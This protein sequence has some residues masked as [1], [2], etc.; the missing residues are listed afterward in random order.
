MTTQHNQPDNGL[1]GCSAVAPPGMPATADSRVVRRPRGQDVGSEARNG[2]DV[3]VEVDAERIV[4]WTIVSAQEGSETVSTI[5][6]RRFSS[7]A[8]GQGRPADRHRRHRRGLQEPDEQTRVQARPSRLLPAQRPVLTPA[9]GSLTSP[10]QPQP[11]RQRR[12]T[13]CAG[14]PGGPPRQRSQADPGHGDGRRL[15]RPSRRRCH[16]VRRAGP[17]R[18]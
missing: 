15:R 18:I 4:G 2:A 3:V 12:A 16:E 14:A 10:G 6:I 8:G 11:P 5:T 7:R 13:A 1:S 9:T 17:L